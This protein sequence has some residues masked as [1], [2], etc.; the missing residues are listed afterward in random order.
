MTD[1]EVIQK[2]KGLLDTTMG[3]TTEELSQVTDDY[4]QDILHADD[5]LNQ[6]YDLINNHLNWVE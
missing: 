5:V 3:I 4:W 2:I 1:L 6:I